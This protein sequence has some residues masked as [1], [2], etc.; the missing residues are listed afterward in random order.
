[1]TPERKPL[2]SDKEIAQVVPEYR[3]YPEAYLAAEQVR[4][5]YES[6]ISSGKLRVVPD[7]NEVQLSALSILKDGGSQYRLVTGDTARVLLFD[8]DGHQHDIHQEMAGFPVL[9][10]RVVE[11]VEVIRCH[12]D[13]WWG[14]M[15]CG[16]EYVNADFNPFC[17]GCGNPIKR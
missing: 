12:D 1:M 16:T 17:P 6:L 9:E 3:F 8:K 13:P 15:G 7:P 4:S 10:L 5:H 14:C 2:L 11:E